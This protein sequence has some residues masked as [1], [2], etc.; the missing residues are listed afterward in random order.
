MRFLPDERLYQRT[1]DCLSFLRS[2]KGNEAQIARPARERFHFYWRGRFGPKQA[3]ALKSF[4]ATQ[5]PEAVEAWL[6]LD[7]E[8]G[9]AAHEEN[10][11]L[12]PL[13][14][15]VAVRRF[16]P[17]VEA[18]GT[19][20][21][22]R[23][24]LLRGKRVATR[25]DFLRLVVLHR[26]GGV[27]ADIDMLFLRDWAPLLAGDRAPRE[28][29]YRLV[30]PAL[31]QQRDPAP[32]PGGGHRGRP[33]GQ[34]GGSG[35]VHPRD[36]LRL[37][38]D[39]YPDLWVL[40]CP[41]FDPL[42]PTHDRQDR[43]A[44]PFRTFPDFFRRFDW[45]FRR[46]RGIRSHRD[47][48]PGAFAYHWH[49]CWEAPEEERSYY[50]LFDRGFDGAPRGAPLGEPLHEPQRGVGHLAPAAVDG[51]GVAAVRDLLDLGHRRVAL[52]RL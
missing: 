38:E 21:E 1:G 5:D 50:G 34:R 31:R 3:F 47:F 24:E 6:W 43:Y 51:Q 45:R 7:G 2:L 44:V 33:A 17:D 41:Y 19:P 46:R 11:L 36:I 26:H 8:D 42:W 10:P 18:R 13:L 49:N 25:S 28:F 20:L 15:L 12:R 22:G 29:C 23:A 40:P 14:P 27:Y 4:L 48:F 32:A 30:G 37:E 39:R 35:S 16:D 9:H 52:C